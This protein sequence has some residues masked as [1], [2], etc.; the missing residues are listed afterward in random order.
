MGKH[1]LIRGDGLTVYY[2]Q[3]VMDKIQKKLGALSS[4][5]K[6]VLKAAVNATAK[7]AKEQLTQKAQET[8]TVKKGGINKASKL[9]RAS[10]SKPTASI[11][12][13]GSPME[14]KKYKTRAGKGG[15]SAQILAAGSLKLIQSQRGS[16][17]KAFLAKFASGH[18]AI[19]QRQDGKTYSGAG[20]ANRRAKWGK[21][22]DM[23]A[24][25]SL[26]SIGYPKMV[27][28]DKVYKELAPKIYE[29]LKANIQ[30]EIEK[31]LNA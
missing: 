14:L 2:D 19:V 4:E 23:T 1:Y 17:A 18:G 26:L 21:G 28:G 20:A 22:A 25:K 31:V 13:S 30:K 24:I 27:G 15:A 10:V 12:V 29:N 6:K 11:I 7:Q 8:Y 5:S 9:K 16:R 3:Q